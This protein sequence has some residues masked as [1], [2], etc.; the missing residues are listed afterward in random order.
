[1]KPTKGRAPESARFSGRSAR[2]L[3]TDGS[4]VTAWRRNSQAASRYGPAFLPSLSG[5]GGF[6]VTS[7]WNGNAVNAAEGT[8]ARRKNQKASAGLS[9]SGFPFGDGH[10]VRALAIGLGPRI[11]RPLG[12]GGVLHDDRRR[13]RLLAVDKDAARHWFADMVEFE[14]LVAVEHDQELGDVG[15]QVDAVHL[16]RATFGGGAGASDA[17]DGACCATAFAIEPRDRLGQH[18]AFVLRGS[19]NAQHSPQHG[20]ARRRQ[21]EGVTIGAAEAVTDDQHR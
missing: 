12:T 6:S 14:Q 8:T 2:R 15:G 10:D 7:R 21:H 16:R 4:T 9:A 1:P 3:A 11:D 13:V 18:L 17:A 19:G 20:N 5:A